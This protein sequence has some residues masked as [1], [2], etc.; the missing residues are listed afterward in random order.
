MTISEYL[1]LNEMYNGN[2]NAIYKHQM[3]QNQQKVREQQLADEMSK[4][5]AGAIEKALD[6]VFKDFK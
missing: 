4:T 5:I 2:P 1:Q 6:N 3:I